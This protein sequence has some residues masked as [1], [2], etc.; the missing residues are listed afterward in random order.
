MKDLGTGIN[1][2]STG[3]EILY[4]D[5]LMS[6]QTHDVVV[7]YHKEKRIPIVKIR[8]KKVYP[9]W[10]PLERFVESWRTSLAVDSNVIIYFEKD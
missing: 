6:N 4:G 2:P 10:F 9:I 1:L 3:Q 5:V 7:M 8:D